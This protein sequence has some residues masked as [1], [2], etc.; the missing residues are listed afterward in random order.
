V[1]QRFRDYYGAT[2]ELQTGRLSQGYG[3][4]DMFPTYFDFGRRQ[5]HI[6]RLPRFSSFNNC[7]Q[8]FFLRNDTTNS[9]QWYP[10]SCEADIICQSDVPAFGEPCE[11]GYVCDERTTALSAAL[12]VCA[13][14]YVCGVGT[15]PD[16]SLR[17]PSGQ[18]KDLCDEGFFC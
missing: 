13:G 12:T 16:V 11:S 7:S 10:G 8:G 18:Y 14:G 2:Y 1:Y 5:V 3:D 6:P 17:A 15:T 9:Q 4:P